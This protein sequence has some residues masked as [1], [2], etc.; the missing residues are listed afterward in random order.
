MG[1][2]DREPVNWPEIFDYIIP[3]GPYVGQ[4]IST[5]PL[6]DIYEMAMHCQ[7]KDMKNKCVEFLET[8][9]MY[10]LFDPQKLN[11]I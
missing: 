10:P 2:M 7:F 4:K 8:A 9:R 1:P 3:H 5:V 11:K 6:C